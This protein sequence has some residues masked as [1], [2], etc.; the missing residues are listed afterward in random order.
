MSRFEEM[1]GGYLIRYA[2]SPLPSGRFAAQ[3]AVFRGSEGIDRVCAIRPHPSEFD[4]EEAA[5]NAG[6][7]AAE[8]EIKTGTIERSD[9]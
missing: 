3:A 4:G 6:L 1:F 7:A 5:A 9:W 2:P 8:N